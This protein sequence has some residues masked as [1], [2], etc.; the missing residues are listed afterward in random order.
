MKYA[1]NR[2]KLEGYSN[3]RWE[4]PG[5]VSTILNPKH[6][7]QLQL[8]NKTNPPETFRPLARKQGMRIRELLKREQQ[9]SGR[10]ESEIGSPYSR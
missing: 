5:D 8:S 10:K 2:P 3:L 9:I 6:R 7:F 1:N 4:Q